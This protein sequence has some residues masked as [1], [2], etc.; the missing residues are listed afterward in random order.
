MNNNK[1]NLWERIGFNFLNVIAVLVLFILSSE[2]ST[3]IAYLIGNRNL[4]LITRTLLLAVMLLVVGSLY[5]K[6]VL[7]MTPFEMGFSLK[8]FNIKNVA[9]C[10]LL[11]VTILLIY[12]FIIPGK[13]IV[14]ETNNTKETIIYALFGSGL[15]AGI[16]EEICFRGLIFKYME[17]TLGSKTAVIV[18]AVLFASLHIFNMEKFDIVDLLLLI[19]AG[20]SVAVMF[21]LMSMQ[22]GTIWVGALSRTLWNAL[23]IGGI[24]GIGDI[25]NG[26]ENYSLIQIIPNTN[27][28]LVTGGNFGVE[29]SIISTLAYIIVA[30][31]F[32]KYGK[33]KKQ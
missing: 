12:S 33:G 14:T 25:V 24:F 27:N 22:T 7:K 23:I 31:L 20:S 19:L 11:P 8:G 16:G 4:A 15:F 13:I 2:V 18:P 17:K 6:F 28:R 10:I 9:V 29:A 21:T 30:L 5:A 32:V 26:M 3:M 1:L